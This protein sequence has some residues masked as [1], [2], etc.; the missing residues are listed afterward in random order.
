MYANLHAKTNLTRA[1]VSSTATA[2][3]RNAT[4]VNFRTST[5]S[6][7]TPPST[8]SGPRTRPTCSTASRGPSTTTTSGWSTRTARPGTFSGPAWRPPLTS[9]TTLHHY[10]QYIES[11][12]N[13]LV[14][15]LRAV[16]TGP[17]GHV[18]NFKDI[19][20]RTGLESVCM[21]ALERRMGFLEPELDFNTQKVIDAVFRY[22]KSST[23]AMYGLPLW[24]Y[25]PASL[26]GCFNNLVKSKDLLFRTFSDIVADTISYEL[27]WGGSGNSILSSLLTVQ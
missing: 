19:I 16:K 15:L 23:E 27:E 4:A 24:K 3:R 8:P 14:G 26:S 17:D 12:S 7:A 5:R 1:V 25:L 11:I 18:A 20:Y 6:S 9:P 10:S 13:D 22:Q 2:Q 21:V